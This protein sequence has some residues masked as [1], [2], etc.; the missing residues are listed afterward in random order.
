MNNK[1]E[2]LINAVKIGELMNKKED[3]NNKCI[4]IF[5]VIGAV[6]AIAAIA[7]G[8]YKFLTPDYED[9]FDDD[10]DSEFDDEFFDDDDDLF[11]DEEDNA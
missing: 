5:A 8:V 9:D 3:K 4:W 6:V 10:F 2:E 11:D 7:Y 1:V